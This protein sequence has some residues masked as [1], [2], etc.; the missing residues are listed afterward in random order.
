MGLDCGHCGYATCAEKPQ[1]NPCAINCI[2]VGIA[3]GS[4]V[5]RAADMRVDSRV[6]FSAGL[7]AEARGCWAKALGQVYAIPISIGSKS[8]FFDRPNT[9]PQA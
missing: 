5:S 9:R 2:D 3:I 1:G 8:P 4:A 7:A 6:L